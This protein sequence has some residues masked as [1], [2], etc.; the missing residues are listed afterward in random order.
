MVNLDLA[1]ADGPL[2]VARSGYELL[3]DP[4][5]NKGISFD[6]AERDAFNLH[7]LLPP[8]VGNLEEQVSRRLSSLREFETDLERYDFLRDMQDNN[9]TAFYSLLVRHTA[10][11]LPIVYTPTVG[12]GCQRF[13][14]I[15]RKP[16]GLFL[17]PPIQAHITSILDQPCFDSVT[18]IV[19][20]DGERILGLG[21]LGAGGMG[22]PVGK[23]SLYTACGG[24]H[25]ATTLPITLDVGTDRTELLTDPGYLGW[26]HERVR[27]ADYDAF[28]E[29]FVAA[30]IARWPHVLLQ[31]EDFALANAT[32]LLDRYRDRLCTFNDDVQ[33]TAAVALGTLLA[34]VTVTGVPLT[35]QRVAI[36]GAGSAGCGIAALIHLAMVQAGM[37]DEVARASIFIIDAPG[38]LTDASS[39][40]L[41]FQKMF[42]QPKASIAGWQLAQPDHVSLV[43]VV[44]N[45]APT[46]LIGVT[47]HPGLFTEAV[48]RTM[49]GQ[50]KRPVIL[51][52]SNPTSRSEGRPV[53]LLKWT[54][55]HAIVCTG[56]P[57]P[58][59]DVEGRS[60]IISQ[61]NNA[62]VF[63]GIG[64]G[65]IAV[66][67]SRITDGM[68]LAAAQALADASP[69]RRQAGAPLLPPVSELRDVALR[70]ALA[71]GLQARHE[72]VAERTTD[73]IEALIRSHMW[74]PAYRPYV[75]RLES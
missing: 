14:Q 5:L 42:T 11:T 57:F 22:I 67:A 34:A 48:V 36:L 50:T 51:P 10:E 37:A 15:Y 52:L 72:S 12:L 13:S 25:P 75:R 71:V 64:L 68:F 23:L 27:G 46:V 24:L 32:R 20:T 26:R 18:V 61:T 6:K 31:W 16:R 41:P 3:N 17:S 21:D 65:A 66:R 55:G 59:V 9:E 47:G 19:V 45:A 1:I 49:A 8:H 28:I 33:G 53:D 7:G 54:D 63:P 60:V 29:V 35:Q 2:T 44:T 58:P 70:V 38:L 62:Y 74:E 4:M 56:S 73:G 69:A 40:L 39:D 43:D 30:V